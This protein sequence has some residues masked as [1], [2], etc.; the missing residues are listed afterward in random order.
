M[1]QLKIV[2]PAS[3]V[4]NNCSRN[5]DTSSFSEDLLPMG[6]KTNIGEQIQEDEGIY[7]SEVNTM[8]PIHLQKTQVWNTVNFKIL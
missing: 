4:E 8:E 3:M 1:Q 2:I 5:S 7:T 6:W